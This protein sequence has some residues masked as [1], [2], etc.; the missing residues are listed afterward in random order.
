MS[1]A[2]LI[3]QL[4]MLGDGRP[5]NGGEM[6][7][8]VLYA[9]RSQPLLVPMNLRSAR[10][11]VAFFIRNP[12]L[13]AWG[14]VLLLLDRLVPRSRLLSTVKLERFP[15]RILFGT[16]NLAETALYWGFPGPLQKLTMYC[17]G[18][19]G[20]QPRV[21]KVALQA[22]ADHAIAQEAHWL[23]MLGGS[24]PTAKYLPQLLDHGTLPCGRRYLAMLALPQGRQMQQFNDLHR[25]FLK[26][27][28]GQSVR[29]GPWRESA[30]FMRLKKRIIAIL[31]LIEPHHQDLLQNTLD[32]ID[33]LIGAQALPACLVHSD[34]TPWNLGIADGKLFVFD[35]EYAEAAG[36]PLQDFLHFHLMPRAL[37][38]WPMRT[39]L[40]PW[41]VAAAAA[42]GKEVFG[43]ESG[44][45]EA[46]GALAL[47]YLL[48]TVT[49]YAEASGYLAP[50]HPV[51]RTYLRLLESRDAW[52]PR[53][54]VE[55]AI[56]EPGR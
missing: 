31:P 26:V 46:S 39:A 25:N 29:V 45:G 12:L 30:P 3:P 44:V 37:Q 1:L 24:Q 20:E 14:N 6:A 18:A 43:S 17:P 2:H 5:E 22:S 47:H 10:Q 21:A 7:W 38:H 16:S 33:R 9:R 36:N 23:G 8:K 52:M 19:D 28:A 41:L 13:R 53:P 40:M 48:D 4:A 56:H 15:A 34:F 50:K 27:L 42:H 49:F 11:A 51:V 55:G 54:I 32:E 35:W